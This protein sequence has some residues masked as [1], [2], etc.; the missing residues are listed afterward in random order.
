MGKKVSAC[1]VIYHEED[2]LKRCLESIKNVVD[3]III[4]HDGECIDRSLE[5]A[6]KYKARIYIRDHVGEAE[7]HR[8]YVYEKARGDWILHIDGDEYLSDGLRKEI[9]RLIKDT[10]GVDAFAF[11]WPITVKGKYVKR[12]YFSKEPRTALFRKSKMY[13]LGLTHEHPRTYGNIKK[14]PNLIL[15]HKTKKHK[16]EIRYTINNLKEK[17]LFRAKL[18]ARQLQD[19]ESLP[20]F[21]IKD[22]TS[23]PTIQYYRKIVKRPIIYCFYEI[24]RMFFSH[25]FKGAYWSGA[26]SL[27]VS[28][29]RIVITVITYYYILISN[30]GLL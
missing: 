4:V 13:M 30:L 20:K 7:Y 18:K 17:G 5:I 2:L 15:E 9:P 22:P 21:N 14:L 8:P 12:G 3:E 10:G 28:V 11:G 23:N 24:T 16:R 26:D 27:R 6:K 19:L 1:L 29:Y 25:L